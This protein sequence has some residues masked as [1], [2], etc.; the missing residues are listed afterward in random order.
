MQEQRSAIS[1]SLKYALSAAKS[2]SGA[3]LVATSVSDSVQASAARSRSLNCVPGF[4][5]LADAKGA[6]GRFADGVYWFHNERT[7]GGIGSAPEGG[8]G[9]M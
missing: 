6:A 8:T 5:Q 2:L 1:A 9:R 7:G 3:W 4:E